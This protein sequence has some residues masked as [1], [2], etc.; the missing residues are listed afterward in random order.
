VRPDKDRDVQHTISGETRKERG[1]NRGKD[2]MEKE[3]SKERTKIAR[4]IKDRLSN[5]RCNF[6]RQHSREYT[7]RVP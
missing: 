3:R 4:K 2:E 6:F 1:R 5:G 7:S